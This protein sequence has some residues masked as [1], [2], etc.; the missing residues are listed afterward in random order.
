MF[1]EF[2][3]YSCRK[4]K[5]VI[6]ERDSHPYQAAY[7][8]TSTSLS[9]LILQQVGVH[10]E[11]YFASLRFTCSVYSGRKEP[12]TFDRKATSTPIVSSSL[13][14]Q[15]STKMLS[16]FKVATAFLSFSLPTSSKLKPVAA[17][18]TNLSPKPLQLTTLFYQN[19]AAIVSN[20]YS[21]QWKLSFLR[22]P[23]E[24]TT[25]GKF[26]GSFL[27]HIA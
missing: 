6:C 2:K 13:P 20:Q 12:N 11:V 18:E 24:L 9:Q 3:H 7:C 14:L 27:D 17:Q 19:P 1:E 22:G 16:N 5:S 8:N 4:R 21:S 10:Y 25:E 26:W 23:T 15:I